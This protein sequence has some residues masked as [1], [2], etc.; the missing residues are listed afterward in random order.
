MYVNHDRIKPVPSHK[1]GRMEP[2]ETVTNSVFNETNLGHSVRLMEHLSPPIS[3]PQNILRS[4]QLTFR[5]RMQMNKL[6]FFN[7]LALD[8]NGIET[9]EF[10]KKR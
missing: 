5:D 8:I 7:P 1:K 9:Q 6:N 10:F 3:V 2:N 4:Q